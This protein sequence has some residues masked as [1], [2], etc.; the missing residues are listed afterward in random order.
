MSKLETRTPPRSSRR[1]SVSVFLGTIAA[2]CVCLGAQAATALA[3]GPPSIDREQ[4]TAG[5]TSAT[6]EVEID[7]N[8]SATTCSMQYV[9]EADFRAT[10]WSEAQTIA[11]PEPAGAGEIE[12]S[13]FVYVPGLTINTSYE[14]R[15]IATSA[16]GTTTAPEAAFVTF[17]FE[18]F[19][20]DALGPPL[21]GPKEEPL[22]GEPVA[23]AGAHPYEL[24]TVFMINS[25]AVQEGGGGEEEERE[26]HSVAT[27]KD[28]K[29]SLPPGLI[30]N[31]AATPK[32]SQLAS[33]EHDCS[34]EDQIGTMEVRA[35]E[36][37]GKYGVAE[38]SPLFNIVPP[39]GVAA[40]FSAKFNGFVNATIDA[41]V[42]TGSDYGIDADSLAITSLGKPSVVVVRMWGVPASPMHTVERACAKTTLGY[43]FGCASKA[44][45]RPFLSM[46]T[47]C[48]G[49]QT[50]IGEADAFQE[51]GD[52]ASAAQQMPAVTGCGE[53]A[54]APTIE[55]QP[56]NTQADSATGMNV[57]LHVPQSEEPEG[58]A[59]SELK[60]A[61]VTFPAGVAVDPSSADGLAACSEKQA[62]FTGFT[63]LDPTG[64][65]GVKTAQFTPG[66][67]EC[68]DASKIGSVQI[69]TPLIEHPLPGAMYLAKQGENPFGSLL[70]VYL[71]VNDPV[72]GVVVKLPG[73]VG[74]NPSTGQ[75]TATFDQN[76]QLPFEDLKVSLFKGERAPLTTPETCGSYVLTSVL[77]P[78]DGNAVLTPSSHPFQVAQ[79]PGGGACAPSEGQAPNS[80]GFEAGTASPIAGSYSPFQLKLTREDG[81]QRFHSLNVT[82]PPGLLGKV[83][84]VEECPQ[85]DIE[86]A[87]HRS[88]EGEGAL[89]QAHPSC[90]AA[91]EVGTLHVGLGSGNPFYA[92]G[93]AYFAGPYEGAPFSLVFVTPALAGPFDLG[94]VVVRAALFINP[95]TAQV[96]VKSDPF[97]SII[98]GIPLDIRSIGVSIDRSDFTLNPTSCNAMAITGSSTSTSGQAASLSD[99]F[100]A[101][102]CA[103]LP[104]KPVFKAETHAD[105]TRRG[106]AFVGVSVATG[107]GEANIHEVHVTLPT[108]LP[109]EL[110]TLKLACTAAQFEANP[111]GCPAGSV[112]GTAVAHTPLLPV[113]ISGPA[114]FVSHGGAGFPNLDLV[115]QGDGVTVTLVG[116]TFI[117]E[118]TKVTT[119]TFPAI[120]DVPV[121][122]FSLQLPP[123]EHPALAGEGNFCAQ[124]LYMPTRIVGQNGGLLE[125]KTQIAVSGCGPTIEV[126]KHAVKGATATIVV[127]VSSAGT[128]TA[129]GRGVSRAVKAVGGT[130]TATVHVTLTKK[131]RLL[132]AKHPKRRLKVR[133]NLGFTPKSGKEVSAHVTV[134]MR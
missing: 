14:Y 5:V 13:L 72:T 67:P 132:L 12:R 117:S 63:E 55:A 40:R 38:N 51:P 45:E 79:A 16:A 112:V 52:F 116:E 70:A 90:P 96:T 87:E 127:R 115:L 94:T 131:D 75:L 66:A 85:S 28:V 64:E 7:P 4:V 119:S 1:S 108:Q 80:P 30:G 57:D 50:A 124:P 33:E 23:L 110:A 99:R 49:P 36:H 8:G 76:P 29:V 77:T 60:D 37:G 130:H 2:A 42:R 105:H 109:A 107:A 17:G 74:A 20:F 86:A 21:V 84:G 43:T 106:G 59:T 104:F 91:S 98:D 95:T 27:L 69:D 68:P 15:F 133:V 35:N 123:G 62:G 19:A 102:G 114:I 26:Y 65:P 24:V 93:H 111:A 56:T 125:Q 120:P 83:A 128:L 31:P 3:V 82:L 122:A 101:G 53:L 129:T 73:L 41:H 32:C 25:N 6:A 89:E 22:P 113:P 100:Q 48:R 97:P 134:L 58:T 47:S 18:S 34:G 126:L 54:F 121:S 81:S 39:R 9:T 71:T 46:P 10:G 92:G 78:W 44:P 118:K 103:S 88:H 11:C 61:T